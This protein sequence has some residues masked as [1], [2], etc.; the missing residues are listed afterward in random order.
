VNQQNLEI[1]ESL[2]TDDYK[3]HCQAMPPDLQTIEGKDIMMTLFKQHFLAFPDWKEETA[4]KAID[5]DI[6]A[7]LSKGTGTQT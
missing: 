6:I 7:Y 1:I 4:I 2:L 3:R 5:G